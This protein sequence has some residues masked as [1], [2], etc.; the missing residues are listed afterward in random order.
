MEP[1]WFP[2]GSPFHALGAS[3][4]DSARPAF[5]GDVFTGVPL[6]YG[7]AF[8]GESGGGF[9]VPKPRLKTVMLW[10]HPCATRTGNEGRLADLVAVCPVSRVSSAAP[11]WRAPW[12]GRFSH[13][14]L[15]G[16][17]GGEDYVA[18]LALSALVKPG[19]LTTRIAQLTIDGLVALQR[20]LAFA[21]TRHDPGYERVRP[22]AE[23]YWTEFELWGEWI[24]LK[25]GAD[26][27]QPWLEQPSP[28]RPGAS[29]RERLL[30][31]L[32]DLRE[33]MRDAP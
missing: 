22:R 3:A 27:F 7:V 5:Q 18:D 16:L 4:A 29:R 24:D 9:R 33:E 10:P 17:E 25:G 13:F 28:E 14:P 2:A 21:A 19:Y 6:V 15:P 23:H 32:E 26:G 1:G 11:D 8:P 30:F 31:D 20:R 12:E